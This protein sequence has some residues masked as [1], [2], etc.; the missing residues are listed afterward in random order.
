MHACM[1]AYIHAYIHVVAY[2]YMYICVC[3]YIYIYILVHII[4]M[5]SYIHLCSNVC[6]LGPR[7]F[8]GFKINE[9]G[10]FGPEPFRRKGFGIENVR[11]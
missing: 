3:I 9:L 10:V 8:H 2:V 4:C 5:I 7:D 1:H 11:V 6:D